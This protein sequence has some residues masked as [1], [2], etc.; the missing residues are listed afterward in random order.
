MGANMKNMKFFGL[1]VISFIVTNVCI[2][3]QLDG[4][5]RF[6]PI[7]LDIY[8]NKLLLMGYDWERNGIISIFTK[9][10]NDTIVTNIS[11]DV[12]LEI[13]N[14]SKVHF[15][16]Y[17]NIWVFGQKYIWKFD[18]AEWNV[19]QAV[20]DFLPER[21]F[22]DFCFDNDNNIYLI[23]WI[24]F[25]KRRDTSQGTVYTTYD[26]IHNELLKIN[27]QQAELSYEV[28]KKFFHEPKYFN[29]AFQA[30]IKRQDGAIACYL[31]DK[32]DN[33]MI[34][35]NNNIT[36]QT[37]PVTPN[38]STIIVGSLQYD[39]KE[40]LWFSIYSNSLP[41]RYLPNNG[42]H[43]ITK[44]GVHTHWDSSAGLRDDKFL[45]QNYAPILGV[46]TVSINETTGL[47]WCGFEY[48]FFSI[49][50]TKPWKEQITFYSHQSLSDS[51][52]FYRNNSPIFGKEFIIED[53]AQYESNTYFAS[54]NGY[55]ELIKE[56]VSSVEREYNIEL[57]D[58][59]DVFPIPSSKSTI[60]I[61][62]ESIYNLKW[63]TLSVIDLSGR[64]V[65]HLQIENTTGKI[66]IPIDSKDMS[67]GTYFA[68][69]KS[70]RGVVSKQFIVR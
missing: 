46:N 27:T 36:Y 33:L 65:K 38:G 63:A 59:I 23:T 44:L 50:E 12:D 7:Q 43:R 41:R 25:V 5:N 40:N 31:S 24:G 22:K 51:F 42:V 68:V 6:A 26:S 19:I 55:I 66:Q 16:N 48:G 58:S 53:I 49:D 4:L 35:N 61:V 15:D 17:G 67:V 70:S 47:V 14:E 21:Q 54:L 52:R 29:G 20:E 62:V 57:I 37:L 2:Y 10:V 11:K 45:G 34:I 32:T 13:H 8:R 30:I 64:T 3:C 28:V 18:G 60:T 9:N 39:S 69:L 1:F 56:T